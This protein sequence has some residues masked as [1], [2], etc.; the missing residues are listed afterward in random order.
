MSRCKFQLKKTGNN[1][2]YSENHHFLVKFQLHVQKS[3]PLHTA[4]TKNDTKTCVKPK[5]SAL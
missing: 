2:K 1:F 5:I 3:D 4:Q